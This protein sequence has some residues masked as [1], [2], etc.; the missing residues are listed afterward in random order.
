[1]CMLAELLTLIRVHMF[2]VLFCGEELYYS[3]IYT[4]E[5]LQRDSDIQ[6]CSMSTR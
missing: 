6:V 3:Y 2:Q 4:S 5:A 1:M